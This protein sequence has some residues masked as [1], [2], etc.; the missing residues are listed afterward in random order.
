MRRRVG[1]AILLPIG[2]SS[3]VQCS[4]CKVTFAS[5]NIGTRHIAAH[6]RRPVP[7]PVVGCHAEFCR[8]DKFAGHITRKHP[9]LG[10][11]VFKETMDR[12]YTGGPVPENSKLW[13]RGISYD[14]R[15][16]KKGPSARLLTRDDPGY[17]KRRN[18]QRVC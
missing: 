3:R 13:A 14:R 2:S 16:K 6:N 7:C 15:G 9:E 5:R 17:Q 1:P 18:R 12:L 11:D 10:R 8:S 4:W